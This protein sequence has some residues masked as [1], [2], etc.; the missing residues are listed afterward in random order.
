M[1]ALSDY[2]Y[3]WLPDHLNAVDLSLADPQSKAE[4]GRLLVDL[5]SDS[6]CINQW[7]SESR[8]WMR[9]WWV[10]DDEYCGWV[11]D[12]FKDSAVS[13]GLQD[14]DKLEW[15]A[16]LTSNSAP[17]DD[18]LRY[19]AETM[20]ARWVQSDEWSVTDTYQWLLGYITKVSLARRI[21]SNAEIFL[22][23]AQKGQVRPRC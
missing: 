17:D 10:F 18:L 16:N 6:E 9:Q 7:W 11:L 22:D 13:K 20:A 14:K 3:F 8:V 19:I 21:L 2:A 12:W 4:I 1:T 15:V 23:T 5:F